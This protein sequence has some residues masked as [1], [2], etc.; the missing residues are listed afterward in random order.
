MCID[1]VQHGKQSDIVLGSKFI[2]FHAIHQGYTP[3]YMEIVQK[4]SKICNKTVAEHFIQSFIGLLAP[5][6]YSLIT[7]VQEPLAI[8]R[9]GV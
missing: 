7:Q 3:K 2:L 5:I 6:S 1:N 8:G 9:C 4:Y